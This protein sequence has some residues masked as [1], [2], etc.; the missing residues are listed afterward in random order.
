MQKAQE[1]P[2][3]NFVICRK[4]QR[5]DIFHTLVPSFLSWS[6]PWCMNR[7]ADHSEP[8]TTRFNG[9]FPNFPHNVFSST[10][11]LQQIS[12]IEGE[13]ANLHRNSRLL[14]SEHVETPRKIRLRLAIDISILKHKIYFSR[15]S[16]QKPRTLR[17][18]S[19]SEPSWLST[20]CLH[21][22][23]HQYLESTDVCLFSKYFLNSSHL[24]FFL[25]Y[26]FCH[27]HHV[28]QISICDQWTEQVWKIRQFCEYFPGFWNTHPNID[29][30]LWVGFDFF[31]YHILKLNFGWCSVYFP[32]LFNFSPSQTH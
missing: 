7:F 9:F 24:F 25:P 10:F 28:V 12:M 5:L 27:F 3:R 26:F 23:S 8:L 22:M 16:S 30:L 31:P 13:F 4:V 1:V 11:F 18:L 29:V 6:R 21:S 15:S 17:S 14:G 2:S 32:L 19:P 20:V